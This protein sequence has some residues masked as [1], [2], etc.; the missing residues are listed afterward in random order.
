MM[1]GSNDFTALQQVAQADWPSL[2]LFGG[3]R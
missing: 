3:L 2:F 1:S